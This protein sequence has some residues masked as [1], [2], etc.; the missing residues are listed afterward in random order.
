M[1]RLLETSPSIMRHVALL[2]LTQQ[3]DKRGM[4]A[5]P[6]RPKEA[7]PVQHSLPLSTH[8][9]SSRKMV[10]WP[11]QGVVTWSILP[12]QGA[13]IHT[14]RAAAGVIYRATILMRL[15]ESSPVERKTSSEW[16]NDGLT[17]GIEMPAAVGRTDRQGV[18]QT[19]CN[20]LRFAGRLRESDRPPDPHQHEID[21]LCHYMEVE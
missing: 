17:V 19:T 13:A 18:R 6:S 14:I 1:S 4:E 3:L 21:A 12:V 11:N 8:N 16:Q 20:G 15:D 10:R 9:R 2:S 7:F 5:E